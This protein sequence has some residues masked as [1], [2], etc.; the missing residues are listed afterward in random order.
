MVLK[1][2]IGGIVI[3]GISEVVCSLLR[4]TIFDMADKK[5]RDPVIDT[6]RGLAILVIMVMH[7]QAYYLH[8]HVIS[9]LW[10]FSQWVVPTIVLCAVAVMPTPVA[11]FDFSSYA[12]YV[13]KRVL[14]LLIPYWISLVAYFFLQYITTSRAPHALQVLANIFLYG[15]VDY[16][17][18]VVL[19][20]Y[21]TVF[22]PLLDKLFARCKHGYMAVLGV[23]VMI[24]FV[25]VSYRDFLVHYSKIFMLPTWLA[26]AMIARLIITWYETKMKFLLLLVAVFSAGAFIS[27]FVLQTQRTGAMVFLFHHKYPPDFV[28]VSFAS[29]SMIIAFYAGRLI[30]RALAQLP[31]VDRVINRFLTHMSMYSYEYFFIHILVL[32]VLDQQKF[33]TRPFTTTL[34][35]LLGWTFVITHVYIYLSRGL[36]FLRRT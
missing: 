1:R 29:A 23:F 22:L 36:P 20:L 12:R 9:V 31:F 32:F 21:L 5:T 8:S 24:S 10:N 13:R 19:F 7:V 25:Y 34:A 11:A 33:L 30:Q 35:V 16:N 27:Y 15:G 26:V 14:R 17:W 2:R 4:T 18:L 6:L 28:F 3:H